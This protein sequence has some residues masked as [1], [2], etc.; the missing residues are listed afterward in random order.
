ML[1]LEHKYP[2]I[3]PKVKIVKTWLS[4]MADLAGI[5]NSNQS[6][7]NFANQIVNLLNMI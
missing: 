4:M 3:T 1:A 7:D 2:Y 5:D 6:N